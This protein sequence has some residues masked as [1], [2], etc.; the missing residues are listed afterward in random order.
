MCAALKKRN[1]WIHFGKRVTQNTDSISFTKWTNIRQRS[2]SRDKL[3]GAQTVTS[4]ENKR[5]IWVG[6][7][8][9]WYETR[10]LYNNYNF[11][12]IT[13]FL[14]PPECWIFHVFNQTLIKHLNSLYMETAKTFLVS[15]VLC[16]ELCPKFSG[17]NA[18]LFKGFKRKPST[19]CMRNSKNPLDFPL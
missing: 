14:Y 2:E 1:S 6:N 7:V 17:D 9:R 3:D 8:G 16:H 12:D 4:Y 15:Y 10:I 11:L 18:V 13:F 19:K 5:I